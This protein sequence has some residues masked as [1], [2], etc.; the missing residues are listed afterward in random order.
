MVMRIVMIFVQMFTSN[1][2]RKR[3]NA[4]PPILPMVSDDEQTDSQKEFYS[5]ENM[6]EGKMAKVGGTLLGFLLFFLGLLNIFSPKS[7]LIH[8]KFGNEVEV[9]QTG[10]LLSG[11]FIIVIGFVLLWFFFLR[12]LLRKKP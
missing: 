11:I 3:G 8:S 5:E 9:S 4:E 2:R 12:H 10:N 6:F 7:S 1:F